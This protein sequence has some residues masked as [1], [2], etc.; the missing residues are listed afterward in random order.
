[1]CFPLRRV[2]REVASTDVIIG[3]VL[4][5]GS[6]AATIQQKD[7]RRQFYAPFSE[8]GTLAPGDV[9]PFRRDAHRISGEHRIGRLIYERH[10]CTPVRD[11]KKK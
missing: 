8:W 2:R 9:V 3:T 1:M 4:T 6:K 10:Y 11:E 7:S 5:V